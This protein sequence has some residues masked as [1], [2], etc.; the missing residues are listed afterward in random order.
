MSIAE[1]IF[2]YIGSHI[3]FAFTVQVCLP[4]GAKPLSMIDQMNDQTHICPVVEASR[5]D[6]VVFA[7]VAATVIPFGIAGGAEAVSV[8]FIFLFPLY[9]G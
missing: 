4:L 8:F 6:S 2:V 1:T 3:S 5:T 9:S 7:T